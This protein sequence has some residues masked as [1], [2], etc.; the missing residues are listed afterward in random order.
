VWK[1]NHRPMGEACYRKSLD[2]FV[3]LDKKKYR[4][5][6]AT[7]VLP[8][9]LLKIIFE[10]ETKWDG[11]SSRLILLKYVFWLLQSVWEKAALH[12][13]CLDQTHLSLNLQ[14]SQICSSWS[15]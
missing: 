2:Q 6:P 13:K 4:N 14:N 12:L 5:N 8:S 3:K 9:P 15:V 7:N 10:E 1:Y 11:L